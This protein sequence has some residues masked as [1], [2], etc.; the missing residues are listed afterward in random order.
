MQWKHGL[1]ILRGRGLSDWRWSA[2]RTALFLYSDRERLAVGTASA[3]FR[4]IR[5]RN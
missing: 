3:R 1:C 2:S 5:R 4:A